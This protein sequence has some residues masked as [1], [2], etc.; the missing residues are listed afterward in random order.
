[1]YRLFVHVN[2]E[3]SN[4]L[5]F[6]SVSELYRVRLVDRDKTKGKIVHVTVFRSH[7]EAKRTNEPR[8]RAWKAIQSVVDQFD[9][10]NVNY[11]TKF[12]LCFSYFNGHRCY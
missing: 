4:G 2:I 1:M 12:T 8:P 10:P 9:G 7:Y 5:V 11:D 6:R 3:L